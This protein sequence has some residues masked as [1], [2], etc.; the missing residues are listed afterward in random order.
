MKKTKDVKEITKEAGKDT[1]WLQVAL[2]LILAL[3]VGMLAV[4]V[5]TI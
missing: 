1:A 4:A 5:V 3:G 2:V